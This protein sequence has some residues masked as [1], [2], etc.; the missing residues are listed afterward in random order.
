MAKQI[1]RLNQIGIDR[2]IRLEWLNLVADL[3]ISGNDKKEIRNYIR[4]YLQGQFSNSDKN[5]RGSFD[6]TVTILMRTWIDVPKD[7]IA[8]QL[9]GLSLLSKLPSDNRVAVHWGMLMAVYPFWG[10]VAEHV[11]RLLRLQGRVVLAQVQRRLREYYGERQTVSRAA[12]RVVR[13]FVD[14]GVLRDTQQKGVYAQGD[15]ININNPKLLVWILEAFLHA[16]SCDMVSIKDAL[17]SMRLF[18]FKM[19]YLYAERLVSLSNRLEIMRQGFNEDVI[20]LK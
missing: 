17:D 19:E 6:K 15:E 9:D 12:Q 18:P 13:S 3:A 8:L 2:R 10:A 14:W 16:N 20:M 7:L 1:D 5:V 4:N 11:G